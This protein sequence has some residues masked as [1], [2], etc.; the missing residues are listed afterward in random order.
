LIDLA[1][2]PTHQQAA[3]EALVNWARWCGSGRGGAAQHPMFRGYQPYLYP[4]ASGGG[5]PVDTVGALAVQRVYVGLPESHRWALRWFYC[6]P[7]ISPGRV[8]RELALTRAG[9]SALVV[10]ARQMMCNRMRA[11]SEPATAA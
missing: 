7:F 11:Q 6:Y 8:Q 5:Q 4:E 9:L 10:D 1:A 3:H 2:V